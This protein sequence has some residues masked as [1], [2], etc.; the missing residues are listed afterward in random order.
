MVGGNFNTAGGINA[1]HIARYTLITSVS[2]S[3][4]TPG[5]FELYQNFPN[6]FNPVTKI[7]FDLPKIS[8]VSLV[9]FDSQG[10]EVK[11]YKYDNLAAGSYS[12]IFDG[13]GL[14]SGI[15]FYKITAGDFSKT[16]KMILIK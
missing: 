5:N 13:S 15:Y 16:N 14:S 12:E 3:S 1:Q 4:Q 11:S 2:G 8:N 7:S 10:K 6:P 9:V